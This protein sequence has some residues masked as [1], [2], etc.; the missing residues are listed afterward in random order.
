[1]PWRRE[2][3]FDPSLSLVVVEPAAARVP[4]VRLECEAVVHDLR[5]RGGRAL[6]VRVNPDSEALRPAT[7]GS[8]LGDDLLCLQ[9]TALAALIRLDGLRR[10]QHG[11]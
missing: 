3:P 7:D 11:S 6:L 1:M 9:E 10:P 8:D 2:L 5:Q 4:S